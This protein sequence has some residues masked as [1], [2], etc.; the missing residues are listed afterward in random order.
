V[1]HALTNDQKH[2]RVQYAKDI[3]KTAG[4]N[5]NFLNSI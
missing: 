5:K 3:V 2:E 4:R 1:P